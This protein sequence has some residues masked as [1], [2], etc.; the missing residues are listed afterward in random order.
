MVLASR[1]SLSRSVNQAKPN[2]FAAQ[3]IR[4]LKISGLIKFSGV[5]GYVQSSLTL[6]IFF[7]QC[8]LGFVMK[9]LMCSPCLTIL[10]GWIFPKISVSA[11]DPT[12]ACWKPLRVEPF[13]SWNILKGQELIPGFNLK[14]S[15]HNPLLHQ[16]SEVV[17]LKFVL[18][19]EW[20][21]ESF[22]HLSGS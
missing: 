17:L 3:L 13:W 15:F 20:K 9:S 16:T 6:L 1:L 21:P 8:S 11:K 4:W 22:D 2:S 10:C 19:S 7:F 14:I 18:F 5:Q 12:S